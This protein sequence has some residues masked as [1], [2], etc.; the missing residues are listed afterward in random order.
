MSGTESGP[1]SSV[2]G[3]L[4]SVHA[5]ASIRFSQRVG[6][7]ATKGRPFRFTRAAPIEGPA[8]VTLVLIDA[9]RRQSSRA[10]RSMA[11][12]A[13]GHRTECDWH[14]LDLL[15]ADRRNCGAGAEGPPQWETDGG[16]GKMKRFRVKY[17]CAPRAAAHAVAPCR[18]AWLRPPHAPHARA[19][20]AGSSRARALAACACLASRARG[21]R[22][23]VRRCGTPHLFSAVRRTRRARAVRPGRGDAGGAAGAGAIRLAATARS[24]SARM[25]RVPPPAAAAARARQDC[26]RVVPVPRAAE[27]AAQAHTVGGQAAHAPECA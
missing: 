13:R 27:S 7:W 9:N 24:R 3:F 22:G 16:N 18:C 20:A 12:T 21:R 8:A 11:S 2:I 17:Q 19:P 14:D 25:R 23:C 10:E 26:V 5:D 6:R 15:P 4:E 1:H